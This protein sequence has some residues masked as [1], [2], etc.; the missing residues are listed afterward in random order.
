MKIWTNNAFSIFFRIANKKML[1]NSYSA[2]HVKY[3]RVSFTFLIVIFS[4]HELISVLTIID[5][6]VQVF[7]FCKYALIVFPSEIHVSFY[8][9]PS[10]F[11]VFWSFVWKIYQKYLSVEYPK[12]KK[13]KKKRSFVFYLIASFDYRWIMLLIKSLMNLN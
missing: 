9:T 7:M 12:K 1:R 2:I 5:L 3:G 13:K 11:I 10:Y 8:S 4:N 6:F